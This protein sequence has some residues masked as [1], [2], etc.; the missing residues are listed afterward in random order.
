M[1]IPRFFRLFIPAALLLISA[2]GVAQIKLQTYTTATDTFYWKHYTHIPRPAKISLQQFVVPSPGRAVESFLLKNLDQFPQFTRDS[3]SNHTVKELKRC[4]YPVDINGDNLPDMIFSG[5]SGGESNMVMIFLNRR[6]SFEL[7]FSDDQYFTR[8]RKKAGKLA[9][10]QTGD[11]G[12]GGNY[13]YFTRDYR[14]ETINGELSFIREKQHV[15]YKYTEEP[16]RYYTS[17]IPFIAKADTM[18]LRA[19]A[20]LL[21]EPFIPRP[22]TFGNIVAKYRE[23]ARGVVL[24]VKSYGNGNDWYF[25]EVSPGTYPSASIL[26]GLDKMPSFIRGWV[27]GQAIFLD[28]K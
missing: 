12:Y 23:K 8:F 21:N 2:A 22:E 26:Y 28:I 11:I 3:L 4:L 13:L 25:V 15:A 10:L 14:V 17:P 27:S 6:D 20:A 16:T 9:E 19:S 5:Y 7:V 1:N 18:L 24:A